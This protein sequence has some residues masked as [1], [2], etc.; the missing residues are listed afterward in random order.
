MVGCSSR[1]LF[2][3]CTDCPGAS[4]SSE[5]SRRQAMGLP[6]SSASVSWYI[7]GRIDQYLRHLFFWLHYLLMTL[8]RGFMVSACMW[9][10]CRWLYFVAAL[11]AIGV[12]EHIPPCMPAFR[13]CRI[14]SISTFSAKLL[15]SS[16]WVP[17]SR[18]LKSAHFFSFIW[19]IVPC[20]FTPP[21]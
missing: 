20:C 12:M 21:F 9:R 6:G 1:A 2:L 19:L 7:S 8:L 14:K 5:G 17:A 11:G 10:Y 4:G 18:A 15:V 16:C 3:S 13:A